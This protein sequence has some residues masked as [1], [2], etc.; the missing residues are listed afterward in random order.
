MR[1]FSAKLTDK[2][3]RLISADDPK[4]SFIREDLR[5]EI[6]KEQLAKNGSQKSLQF[7]ISF[8]NK[9]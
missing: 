1:K 6:V 5:Q 3:K 8:A 7:L 4:N 2:N 9:K